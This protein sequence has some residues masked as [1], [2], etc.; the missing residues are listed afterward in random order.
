MQWHCNQQH[1]VY[2]WTLLDQLFGNALHTSYIR[3]VT[4]TYC[5]ASARQSA[6]CINRLTGVTDSFRSAWLITTTID[7]PT[8]VQFTKPI[9]RFASINCR[10]PHTARR[11]DKQAASKSSKTADGRT[12][13][14]VGG[15]F[16]AGA[17]AGRVDYKQNI[18]F[19]WIVDAINWSPS[20]SW[21]KKTLYS[22]L[23]SRLGRNWL[24]LQLLNLH[25]WYHGEVLQIYRFKYFHRLVCNAQPGVHSCRNADIAF[26]CRIN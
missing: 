26:T 8:F 19:I 25:V 22:F 6:N 9:R 17:P 4:S 18:A 1:S 3:E 23:R 13:A 10:R 16:V 11:L 24:V 12:Q 21:Q 2:C 15:G 20:C 5:H 7:N 14:T